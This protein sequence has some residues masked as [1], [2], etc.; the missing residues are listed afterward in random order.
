MSKLVMFSDLEINQKRDID[1]EVFN[2]LIG[3]NLDPTIAYIPSCS[4]LD[5]RYYNFTVEYYKSIGI[6]KI[7]Y[8]DLDLEYEE[9]NIIELLKYDAI[10]LSGGNTYYFLD[11]IKKRNFIDLLR[12]YVMNNGILIGVSAGSIIMTNSIELAG[13]GEVADQNIVNLTNLSSLGLVD[14]EFL[15]HWNDSI[16]R[17]EELR[18]YAKIKETIIYACKDNEGIV[19]DNGNIKLIGQIKIIN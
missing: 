19:V 10:H 11:V 13:Y 1:N 3:K 5:R 18:R 4:D 6:D 12:S 8:F 9:S 14:F 17:I 15:P 7:K 2:L 16:D